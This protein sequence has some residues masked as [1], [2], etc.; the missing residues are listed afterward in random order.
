MTTASLAERVVGTATVAAGVVYSAFL[1]APL[2]GTRLDPGRS[3]VSELAALDQPHGLAFRVVDAVVGLV[4]VV[5]G[6]QLVHGTRVPAVRW[7]GAALGL[8]GVATLLDVAAPMTCAPSADPACAAAEASRSALAF[9]LHELAGVAS[10]GAAVLA[11]VLLVLAR[12]RG[13]T[14]RQPASPFEGALLAGLPLIAVPGLLVILEETVGIGLDGVVGYVQRVQVLAL[15]VVLVAVGLVVRGGSR[16]T[17]TE[18][19]GGQGS[20]EPRR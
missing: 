1:V 2:L 19:P 6:V 14:A 3:F 9:G 7:A 16:W 8:F 20:W 5:A 17:R 15:S 4:V 10:N 18:R 13:R 12:S 11:A